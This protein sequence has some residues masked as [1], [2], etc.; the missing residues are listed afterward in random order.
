MNNNVLKEDQYP[1]AEEMLKTIRIEY[2]FENDRKRTLD[3]KANTFIT[4]NIALITLFIPLIPL[5]KVSTF[6]A[7]SNTIEKRFLIFGLVLLVISLIILVV[8][9]VILMKM[10]SVLKYNGVQLNDVLKYSENDKEP[11]ITYIQQG[12]VEHYYAILVG[13]NEEPGN[14]AIND[15]RAKKIQIGIV[16]TLIGYIMLFFITIMFRVFIT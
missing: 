14:I 7:T 5:G 6:F 4:F 3:T 12:L 11:D 8:S 9:F 16:L 13:K 10:A 1:Y 15:S 2:D